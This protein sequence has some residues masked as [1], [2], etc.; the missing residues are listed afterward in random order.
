MQTYSTIYG[1]RIASRSSAERRFAPGVALDVAAERAKHE[2]V[3]RIIVLPICID[4]EFVRD[5]GDGLHHAER[6]D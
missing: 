2:Q 5:G 6:I 3:V 4:A 1:K